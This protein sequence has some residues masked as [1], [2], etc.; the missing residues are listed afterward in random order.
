MDFIIAG[1]LLFGAGLI[2]LAATQHT[3]DAKR[4]LAIGAGVLTVLLFVWVQ[5]AVGIFD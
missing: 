3:H 5:L 1:S 4:R 2:Y